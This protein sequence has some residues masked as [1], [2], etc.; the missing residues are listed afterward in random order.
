MTENLK[1]RKVVRLGTIPTYHG[2][3]MSIYCE[4][5]IRE[6]GELS[7]CGVE[8]PLAGGDCL[9]SCGQIDMHLRDQQD[10]ITLARGWNREK[11]EGFFLIWK[12]WHLNNM[13]A[14]CQHQVGPDWNVE[15]K[16]EVVSY[17]LTYQASRLRENILERAAKAG[18]S[19]QSLVLSDTERALAEM[20]DWFQPKYKLPEEGDPLFG[21][22]EV[23]KRE[24]KSIGWV[25]PNEHPRGILCKPC[26][27]CGYKYGTAWNKEELPEAVVNFLKNLPDSDLTPSWV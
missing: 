19:G 20:D 10:K 21:C 5:K 16:V 14:N 11:L 25:K 27:V 3:P 17:K 9:G 8:G 4:I 15:E 7:I 24:T 13:K 1:F 22:F 6:D 2:N 26:P 18:L 23:E 12:R